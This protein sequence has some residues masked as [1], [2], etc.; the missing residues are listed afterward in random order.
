VLL[1]IVKFHGSR[2]DK[3]AWYKNYE[4][5]I[6]LIRPMV[7]EGTRTIICVTP[8]KSDEYENF[9]NHI[10]KHHRWLED[11]KSPHT[12][13]FG[14][15]TGAIPDIEAL[16]FLAA[17][18][19]YQLLLEVVTGEEGDRIL[20]LLEKRLNMDNDGIQVLYAL[21]EIE[22]VLVSDHIGTIWK[23]EY[24]LVSETIYS[25]QGKTPRFQRLFQIARN[26]HFKVKILE[27]GTDV[28]DRIT[29]FGGLLCIVEK[30][31]II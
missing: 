28:G 19:T 3:M 31:E 24:L 1:G 23:P 9:R 26:K 8:P 11:E 25:K 29:Q 16:Q 6:D 18:E 15:L 17:T 13:V 27:E 7:R 10:T 2:K 21:E 14:E 5:L 30:K 22:A 4:S 12:V 20:A